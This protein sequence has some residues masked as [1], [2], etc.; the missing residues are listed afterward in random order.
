M[1]RREMDRLK[2]Y[3]TIIAPGSFYI[4]NMH[5]LAT[6]FGA[7]LGT[8]AAALLARETHCMAV[9]PGYLRP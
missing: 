7:G 4:G 3:I 9:V 6:I 8:A 1:F 5:A 2:L